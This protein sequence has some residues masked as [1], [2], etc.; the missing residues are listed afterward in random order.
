M[1]PRP[2]MTTLFLV[3]GI[4][5]DVR[6]GVSHRL[7]L[8]GRVVR[9]REVKGVLDLHDELDRVQ[10][11]GSQ[12][13][14]EGGG[15]GDLV[16]GYPELLRY[17]LDDLRLDFSRGCH[18]SSV[19]MGFRDPVGSPDVGAGFYMRNIVFSRRM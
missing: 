7:D 1:T 17:D 14:D 18:N 11:V 6:D 3:G 2:V 5:L 13:I 15:A 19:M 16:L 4:L 9:D 8:L 10:G 12:V